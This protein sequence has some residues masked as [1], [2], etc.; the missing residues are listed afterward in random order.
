MITS[1]QVIDI[2]EKWLVSKTFYTG[3]VDIFINPSSSDWIEIRKSCKYPV[4]RFFADNKNKKV[5]VWDADQAIHQS[6]ANVSEVGLSS[7]IQSND[8]NIIAGEAGLSSGRAVMEGSHI[9]EGSLRYIEHGTMSKIETMH[10]QDILKI[11]WTW[12]KQYVD[13]SKYLA[14]FKSDLDKVIN[15]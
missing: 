7:R 6:V 13:C 3:E 1:K 2:A 14:K 8:P 15:R 4:V 11:D 10:L 5:Y 12:T 9:M